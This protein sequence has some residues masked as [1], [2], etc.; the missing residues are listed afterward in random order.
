MSFAKA[1]IQ[2]FNDLTN[3]VPPPGAYDPKFGPK[4]KGLAIEKKERFQDNI[5]TTSNST[6]SSLNFFSKSTRQQLPGKFIAPQC[7]RKRVVVKPMNINC[8]KGKLKSTNQTNSK[9]VNKQQYNSTDQLLE[10]QVECENKNRTIQEHEKQIEEMK[11]EMCKLEVQIEELHKKQIEV[12]EQHKKDIETMAKLQQEVLDNHDE[13]HQAEVNGLRSKLLDISR[14]K[15]EEIFARRTVESDLRKRVAELSEKILHLESEMAKKA[16]TNQIMIQTLET[17]TEELLSKLKA[18]E[19][20]RNIQIDLLEKEKLQCTLDVNDLTENKC[21]LEAKLEKRQNVILELQG[22]LSALQCELDEL[23]AE[24]DKLIDDSMMQKSQLVK[25][26]NKEKETSMDWFLKEKQKLEQEHEKTKV[27]VVK[28]ESD[29]E[30][31]TETKTCLQHELQDMKRLYTDV[32]QQLTQAHKELEIAEEKHERLLKVHKTEI[33]ALKKKHHEENLELTQLLKE[34]K[35]N[36]LNEIESLSIAKDKEMTDYK[37]TSQQIKEENKQITENT[38]NFVESTNIFTKEDNLESC[39]HHSEKKVK[40]TIAECDVKIN[41]MI[42]QATSEIEEEMRLNDEKYKACLA[43]IESER[44]ALENKLALRDAEIAKLSSIIEELK[45]SAV[46]QINLSHSLQVELDKAETELGDKKAELRALKDQIRSE[47]AELVSRRKRFEII[48]TEN[49]AAFAAVSEHLVQ[50]NAEVER[51]QYELRCAEDCLREHRDLLISI[52]SNTQMVQNY[53]KQLDVNRQI[54]NQIEADS[55][56]ECESMKKC[57]EL[58]IDEF[59]QM[60]TKEINLLRETVKKKSSESAEMKKQLDEMAGSLCTTRDMLL[61]L[62]QINDEREISISRLELDNSKLHEQLKN[63]KKLSEEYVELLSKLS[64]TCNP[65]V[66]ENKHLLIEKEKEECRAR[67]EK[68][69]RALTAERIRRKGVEIKFKLLAK[70]NDLLKKEYEEINEKYAHVLGHQNH[71]Q[72]I[73]HVSF[74]KEKISRLEQELQSKCKQLEHQQ[75]NVTAEKVKTQQKRSQ[76][77][78]KENVI[79]GGI[80]RSSH[81]TPTSSPHKSLTPLRDRNE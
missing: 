78:G 74:L 28:L 32:S 51:L 72:R 8:M 63:Q 29:L 9:S 68:L 48:M 69:L 79:G 67:E 19:E 73:M 15:E 31:V 11:E 6:E 43:R 49:K 20:E 54:I 80:S 13:R 3:K 42:K 14:E 60:A 46:I 39:H 5:S 34:T 16:E 36:Y 47:A 57:Y 38:N 41:T 50:S 52:C 70:S 2:R 75:Q 55:I 40:E 37:K 26:H 4:V 76:T 66:E 56:F 25:K 23:R 61:S 71:Q 58:K 44:V 12:E 17:K 21:E 53:T 45:S 65:I 64:A 22:Q 81:T 35:E 59:K 7:V 1:R 18:L 24:Y 33:E 77:K 30:K 27:T 62:E 10:L